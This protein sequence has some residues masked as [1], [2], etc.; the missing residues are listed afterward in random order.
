MINDRKL[1]VLRI[2]RSIRIAEEE[3]IL[4][5]HRSKNDHA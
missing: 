1:A 3:L 5:V 2:G 4:L